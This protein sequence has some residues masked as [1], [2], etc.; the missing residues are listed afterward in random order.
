MARKPK[1]KPQ[2]EAPKSFDESVP[3]DADDAGDDTGPAEPDVPDI[4]PQTKLRDWR[5]VERY[6]EMRELRK[7]VGDDLDM[8]L[9]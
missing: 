8:D 6:K 9:D 5:D 4:A 1:Q 3:F 7:V 2:A